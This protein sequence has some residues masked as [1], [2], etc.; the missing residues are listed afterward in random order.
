MTELNL[1]IVTQSNRRVSAWE[2][3]E[4]GGILSGFPSAQPVRR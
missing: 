2:R 3:G 4:T 1:D